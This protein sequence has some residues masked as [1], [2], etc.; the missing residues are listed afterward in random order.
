MT[1]TATSSVIGNIST[2]RLFFVLS[3]RFLAAAVE[4]MN[5]VRCV[6]SDKFGIVICNA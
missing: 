4:A 1:T 6:A 5:R 3:S 2:T